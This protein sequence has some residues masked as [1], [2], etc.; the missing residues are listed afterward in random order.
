MYYMYYIIL[1]FYKI[2][3]ITKQLKAMIYC[4]VRMTFCLVSKFLTI[5][6]QDSKY[7]AQR[8]KKLSIYSV[9]Y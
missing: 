6:I 4:V 5:N 9:K 1:M 2:F 3:I 7:R 8:L